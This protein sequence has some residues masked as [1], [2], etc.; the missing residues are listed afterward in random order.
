ME[1]PKPEPLPKKPDTVQDPEAQKF[2]DG[3]VNQ[4]ILV[5]MVHIPTRLG[6]SKHTE[7][8]NVRNWCEQ[9]VEEFRKSPHGANA[10]PSDFIIVEIRKSGVVR[11]TS[12]DNWDD[13]APV[14]ADQHG[15]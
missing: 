7:L 9:A 4:E 10:Q 11:T 6:T 12:L 3:F 14:T 2:L 1:Y 8:K 13:A 15:N 5:V